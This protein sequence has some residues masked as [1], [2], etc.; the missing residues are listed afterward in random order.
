MSDDYLWDGSGEVDPVV[1][2]LEHKLEVLR[3][4]GAVPPLPSARAR[5]PWV[6]GVAAA[7]G[8]AGLVASTWMT[9]QTQIAQEPTQSSSQPAAPTL[10]DPFPTATS[11]AAPK[12]EVVDPFRDEPKPRPKPS[13]VVDPFKGKPA[14]S[15]SPG[16]VLD[17]FAGPRPATAAGNPSV[18]PTASGGTVIDPWRQKRL[19]PSAIRNTVVRQQGALAAACWH[20]QAPATV[21]VTLTMRIAPSGR[22]TSAS[23]PDPKGYPGLGACIAR[24]AK[25][26]TFPATDAGGMVHVPLVFSR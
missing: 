22:V 6:A 26:L 24:Q 7:A 2:E 13:A 17:P 16:E 18:K 3:F 8:I 12:S 11:S 14:A 19:S 1:A 9:R 20:P 15:A 5:W 25:G 21:R 23:A 4:S 10:K